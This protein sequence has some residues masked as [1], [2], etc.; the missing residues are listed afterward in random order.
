MVMFKQ[1]ILV[2]S[3]LFVSCDNQKG[4]QI[5]WGCDPPCKPARW[6][7]FS[8]DKALLF[9]DT[10]GKLLSALAHKKLEEFVKQNHGTEISE[11][12]IT[13]ID[14]SLS[15]KMWT[16]AHHTVKR[17]RFAPTDVIAFLNA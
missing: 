12:V 7:T 11:R 9:H 14:E 10:T 17:N 15:C 13:S 6:L 1:A 2:L 16:C 3:I 4:S 8:Y 5:Q